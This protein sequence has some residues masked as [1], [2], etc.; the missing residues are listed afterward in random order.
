MGGMVITA[1]IP[2]GGGG[3]RPI[4]LLPTLVRLWARIRAGEVQQWEAENERSY[5]YGGRG[6]GAAWKFA[7]RAEA[8][9]LQG[10]EYAAVLLDQDKAF[11]RVPH[12]HV[13]QAAREWGYP[14]AVLRLS[15]AAYRMDRVVGI[16]GVFSQTIRPFRGLAAGSVHATRELRALMIGVFDRV[17]RVSPSAGLTVYV[18]DSTIEC[19]GTQRTIVEVV[20][21]ATVLVCLGLE[22]R[23][24]TFSQTKNVVIASREVIGKEIQEALGRWGGS[25]E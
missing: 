23:G 19:A 24:I 6:K 10:A 15:L 18:D 8:V 16:G 14:I 13:V 5:F 12:H 1:L 21:G 20:I 9:R 22:E 2:K 4:G 25:M 3:L 7:A 17:A 11:D